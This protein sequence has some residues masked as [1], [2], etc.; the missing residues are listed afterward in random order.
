LLAEGLSVAIPAWLLSWLISSWATK[1]IPRLVPADFR[2][3]NGLR[4]N[5]M[6]VDFAP[7]WPVLG[8]AMILALIATV[9]FTLCLLCA[10][11]AVNCY[12]V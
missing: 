12:R 9:A 7:D 6:N 10:H 1:W 5:H 3:P 11:G 2:A 4:M 8:Y